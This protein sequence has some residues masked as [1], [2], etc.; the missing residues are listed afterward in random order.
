MG[1][2]EARS[3]KKLAVFGLFGCVA[4]DSRG[5]L[6]DGIT[7]DCI[8]H[9]IYQQVATFGKK[10]ENYNASSSRSVRG[11]KALSLCNNGHGWHP[12]VPQDRDEE[13]N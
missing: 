7:V 2:E 6:E 13:T 9:R 1:C 5:V 12:Y 8:H 10:V 3:A 4:K 11:P